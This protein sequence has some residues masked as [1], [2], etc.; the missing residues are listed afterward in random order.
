MLQWIFVLVHARVY[1]CYQFVRSTMIETIVPRRMDAH[2]Q[3]VRV[4]ACATCWSKRGFCRSWRGSNANLARDSEAQDHTHTHG[5]CCFPSSCTATLH[6]Y[7]YNLVP[8]NK[9]TS[10]TIIS[11]CACCA[12]ICFFDTRQRLQPSSRASSSSSPRSSSSPWS[13]RSYVQTE[14]TNDARSSGW[15]ECLSVLVCVCVYTRIYVLMIIVTEKLCWWCVVGVHMHTHTH[16]WMYAGH[17]EC[18]CVWPTCWLK[19]RIKKRATH[20]HHPTQTLNA[21]THLKWYFEHCTH[22]HN[23]H[24][25]DMSWL[26]T[27]SQLRLG[28]LKS[29]R[30]LWFWRTIVL[31]IS[32]WICVF[33]HRSTG[34]QLDACSAQGLSY[35]WVDSSTMNIMSTCLWTCTF[36]IYIHIYMDN[37]QNVKK[38]HLLFIN[39]YSNIGQQSKRYLMFFLISLQLII[40]II[41]IYPNSYSNV[42]FYNL[43]YL[44]TCFIF[45]Y[46]SHDL[47]N[48]DKIYLSKNN[49]KCVISYTY[50]HHSCPLKRGVGCVNLKSR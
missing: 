10:R 1:A 4:C 41:F 18:A 5:T 8:Y 15:C 25:C 27:D 16:T 12:L 9:Y 14:Y 38:K 37:N 11:V 33:K 35:G 44:F 20:R 21:K 30:R 19:T 34:V 39:I 48:T 13:L 31:I 42:A 45:Y 36:G 29:Q 26:Y 7:Y 3:R 2:S 32:I 23:T 22:T 50:D 47:Q 24:T 43:F 6:E 49:Q 40:F 17:C 28:Q 46:M